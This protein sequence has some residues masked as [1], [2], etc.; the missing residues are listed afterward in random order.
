[1][2]KKSWQFGAHE[3]AAGGVHLA[4]ERIRIVGGGALQLFTRNQRQWEAPEVSAEEALAFAR[5]REAWG[6]YPVA[7]HASYLINMASPDPAL[8]HRSALA[9]AAELARCR[10]LAIAL[11]A[12]HPG[13]RTG[14]SP[15]E[16]LDNAAAVLDTALEL[17]GELG[18]LVLLENTAGQGSSLGGNL[19]DLGAIIERS[20]HAHRLGLCFDTCHAFA[21]G[22]DIRDRAG[23]DAALGELDPGRLRLVHLNDCKGALGSRLDRHEHI[24]RGGIGLEGFRAVVNHPRL[25]GLPM[26]LETHKE[27]DLAL[28][29]ENLAVLRSLAGPGPDGPRESAL[30]KRAP[31]QDNPES[32]GQDRTGRDIASQTDNRRSCG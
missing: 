23:L 6:P 16:A 21:A 25:A 24:G 8:R 10:A 29:R 22:Y 9:L 2:S 15:E 13:A 17:A 27:K 28:D 26:V 19:G 32:A 18:P 1:M 5:A 4:V 3:S 11:L 12:V 7:S 14:A 31:G 20:R 30:D